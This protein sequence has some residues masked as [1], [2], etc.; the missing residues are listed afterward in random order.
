MS[1]FMEVR[2]RMHNAYQNRFSRQIFLKIVI[3]FVTFRHLSSQRVVHDKRKFAQ[4]RRVAKLKCRALP[5]SSTR[6]ATNMVSN[7]TVSSFYILKDILL[8]NFL[9]NTGRVAIPRVQSVFFSLFHSPQ[10]VKA[11]QYILPH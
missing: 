11:Y 1:R 7:S 9:P 8:T 3:P 4:G 2:R 5:S 10:K 6:S